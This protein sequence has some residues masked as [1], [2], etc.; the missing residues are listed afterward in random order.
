[1]SEI[2]TCAFRLRQSSRGCTIE[3]DPIFKYGVTFDRATPGALAQSKC[4]SYCFAHPTPIQS[5]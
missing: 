2:I 1:M 5:E 3:S 4:A